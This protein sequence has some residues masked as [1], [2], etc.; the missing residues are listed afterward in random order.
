MFLVGDVHVRY[1]YPVQNFLLAYEF[2]QIWQGEFVERQPC[3][4]PA[5]LQQYTHFEVLS[6]TINK[7]TL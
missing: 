5:E 1:P 6:E 3:V 2:G 4:P 7:R